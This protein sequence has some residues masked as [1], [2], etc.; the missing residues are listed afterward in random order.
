MADRPSGKCKQ[1]APHFPQ[2]VG[3]PTDRLCG[4]TYRPLPRL[5]RWF[6]WLRRW[7]R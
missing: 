3:A 4:G 6:L 5:L 2:C 7:P 1:K